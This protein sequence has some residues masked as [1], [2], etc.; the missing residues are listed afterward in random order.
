MKI[1]HR[2]FLGGSLPA[3]Q[4]TPKPFKLGC[5]ALIAAVGLQGCGANVNEVI[6]R[7]EETSLTVH[8]DTWPAVESAV[9]R[10][11][12]IEKRVAD[13][14]GRMT[15]E[16]KVGQMIQAEINSV[17]PEEV[18]KYNLG[19]V[20]NGGGSWPGKNKYATAQDWAALA[21]AFYDASTDTSDGG[22]GVPIIWG[23][24]A[25]HGHNNVMGATIYPHNIGLGAARD[26]ELMRKIA[27]ATALE[28]AATG[29]DW[30][31]A[32]TLAV[33]RDDRWG[34]SYEGYSE[35]PEI[36]A[37]YAGPVVEGVQ[38]VPGTDSFMNKSH[39]L[40]NAKHFVGDGG[41]YLGKDQGDNLASEAELRDIHAA[42]YVTALQSGAQIVMTS[43]SSWKGMKMHGHKGLVTDVLKER[44]GFDGFVVSDWNAH[45]QVPGCNLNSCP[46][47]IIAGIDMIMVPENWKKL[48]HN[49][50][51]EVNAGVIPMSRIDDAV[52]RILRVKARSGLLDKP[53]PSAR[54]FSG[55]QNLLGSAEHRAIAREAVRKSIVL[56]KNNEQLLPLNPKQNILV[57]GDGANDIGK[58]C[59]GWTISWQGT[60][61]TNSDFPNGVSIYQAL[62]QQV[63]QAGGNIELMDSK[64]LSYN[65]K[66]DVAVMVY[67]ENPYAEFQGDRKSLVY[68]DHKNTNLKLLQELKAQNIPVVS[69]FLSGRPLWVNP[70]LNLSQSFVAA[71][72]PGSEGSGVADV[73]LRDAQGK[74]QH[75]FTGRLSF[76]WLKN[77]DQFILNHDQRPYDPLFAYGYGLSYNDSTTV[78]MLSEDID[79]ESMLAAE[80]EIL[81]SEGR[82]YMPWVLYIQDD[83]ATPQSVSGGMETV[84]D[85]STISARLSDR[86]RQGDS[87]T[88]NW[89]KPGKASVLLAS[90]ETHDFSDENKAISLQ[91][92]LTQKPKGDVS[93]LID[94]GENC[95][96]EIAMN[97]YLDALPKDKWIEVNLPLSCFADAGGKLNAVE[98]LRIVSTGPLSFN[99]YDWRV[100]ALTE[101]IKCSQ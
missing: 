101:E 30:T 45:A 4:L 74:I 13:L 50:V 98:A 97:A 57:L 83:N 84:S 73:L 51:K 52:T 49:T 39:L 44:M 70:Y 43:F 63:E 94:C 5:L 40:A 81:F 86:N 91:L 90:T 88:F 9:K 85:S 100:K 12:Q 42:G 24:D 48:Y 79:A 56:L 77:T 29:L 96:R 3:K 89:L 28:V 25:V 23:S 33:V 27:T 69:V 31:F 7:T 2:R 19:S 93:M 54:E 8:P 95:E 14:L 64:S 99:L 20:L 41:T 92:K 60:G 67:G 82:A 75:D 6:S 87:V 58:Q 17:T 78:G 15:V 38:G 16:E 37:S 66:P 55:Q 11:E 46:A 68:Q 21:D 72:L 10:D 80:T 18:K 32:P 76:S 59:G 71:F 53:K 61:N 26:P 62:Q 1:K 65:A 34:R 35:S 47:A 22:V 36:V